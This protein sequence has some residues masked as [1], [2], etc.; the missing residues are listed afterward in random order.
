MKYLKNE[1]G[2]TSI[3]VVMMIFMLLTL[4]TAILMYGSIIKVHRMAGAVADQAALAAANQYLDQS[5]M[6]PKAAAMAYLNQMRLSSCRILENG[7]E[8]E[9]AVAL[10]P[11]Q[12]QWL[13]F[14]GNPTESIRISSRAGWSS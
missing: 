1:N 13:N 4:T 14:V 10:S 2:A 3:L 6:C 9:V 11:L 7:I 8:V 12:Q 5:Q